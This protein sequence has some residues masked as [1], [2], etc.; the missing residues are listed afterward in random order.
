M[1][2]ILVT[3]DFSPL[4]DVAI[5]AAADMARGTGAEVTLMHVIT[6]DRHDE[7]DP[8]GGHYKLAKKLYEADQQREKDVREQLESRAKKLAGVKAF[9]CVGRGEA[10]P[11]ILTAAKDLGVDLIVIASAGRTGLSR[12]LL[13]SVA[14]E[15]AR[16][17]PLPVLI[18]KSAAKA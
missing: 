15:L 2:H 6:E 4:A 10:V 12:L 18:W 3:T 8:Q 17:S 5:A 11:G 13:G 9:T 1:K 14:E 16:S 7:P